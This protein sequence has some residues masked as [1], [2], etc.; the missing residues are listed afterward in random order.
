M[1]KRTT[2]YVCQSCGAVHRRWQGR[3]DGCGAWNTISEETSNSGP[4]SGPA[5][6]VS[7]RGR[8]VALVPL[9][10]EVDEAPRVL[11]GLGEFDRVTGGG[12]VR[13]SVL[14]V[15]GDPGIGKSTLLTQATSMLARAGHRA[16][17]ISGAEAIAQVRLRAERLGMADAAVELA[18][19]T[20]VEDIIATLSLGS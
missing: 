15:G 11:S 6:A 16:V 9:K 18:A 20:S 17:Y 19:E 12:F 10:G 8:R 7:R 1:A 14:L 13:G 2:T 5:R 4:A 3:C